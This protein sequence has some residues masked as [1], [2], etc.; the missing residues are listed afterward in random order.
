MN[1]NKILVVTVALFII[2]SLS[3]G[4]I[5][6]FMQND[7]TPYGIISFEF[8]KTI[9]AANAAMT[10]WGDTGK[11]A[12]GI[13]LGLDY[14]YIL[15]YSTMAVIF[16]L[17]T[18]E[19]VS[20]TNPRFGKT[21]RSVAYAFPIVGILDM[22]ENFGLIQVL[23]GSQNEIWPLTAYYFASAKFISLGI[24]LVFLVSGQLYA[25]IKAS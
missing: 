18:S 12:T 14:L 10:A 4:A 24:A 6:S 21:I 3:M 22:I 9:D 13:S 11:S 5:D 20:L 16:L 25:K 17:I 15:I 8:I 23:L 19:K 2:S 1:R 7:T